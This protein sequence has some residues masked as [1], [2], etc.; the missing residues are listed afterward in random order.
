MLRVY[1]H[2]T[3]PSV[4]ESSHITF[5]PI[6]LPIYKIQISTSLRF[7]LL[8][9]KIPGCQ[10]FRLIIFYH[11]TFFIPLYLESL[12]REGKTDLTN[13]P[14]SSL[15]QCIISS[16]L[17]RV[18]LIASVKTMLKVFRTEQLIRRLS[19]YIR[20]STFVQMCVCLCSPLLW[21]I[22]H[23]SDPARSDPA[24]RWCSVWACAARCVMECA[25]AHPGMLDPP[26]GPNW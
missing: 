13:V 16:S 17:S 18:A 4:C 2:I 22:A 26:G 1:D 15:F 25:S 8:V 21:L 24:R 20:R 5:F 7:V 23:L 9:T 12:Y 11:N 3:L 19:R 10:L 6:I 14:V